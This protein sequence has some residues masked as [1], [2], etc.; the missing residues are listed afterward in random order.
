MSRLKSPSLGSVEIDMDGSDTASLIGSSSATSELEQY[1]LEQKRSQNN[2]VFG[3]LSNVGSNL[4]KYIPKRA[5]GT[6]SIEDDIAVR[7]GNLFRSGSTTNGDS[8]GVSSGASTSSCC[9]LV[10]NHKN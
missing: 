5:G 10:S 6:G 3:Y 8:S 2:N 1:L 7:F 4:G 9:S